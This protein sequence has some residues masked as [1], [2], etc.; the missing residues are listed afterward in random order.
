M[1]WKRVGEVPVQVTHRLRATFARGARVFH[2][3]EASAWTRLL[4]RAA[5][6]QACPNP[7]CARISPDPYADRDYELLN[8]RSG[9]KS[10]TGLRDTPA[11]PRVPRTALAR[12]HAEI[13]LRLVDS[14]ACQWGR[15]SN[16]VRS[17]IRR[18]P[19]PREDQRA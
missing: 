12:Y 3:L 4:R 14:C 13:G 2:I 8:L 18:G 9:L 1:N 17:R 7:N 6:S 11:L 16:R 5:F 15:K 10:L 19:P